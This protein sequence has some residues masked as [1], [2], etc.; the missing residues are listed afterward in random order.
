MAQHWKEPCLSLSLT[1]SLSTPKTPLCDYYLD[2]HMDPAT[3]RV[4]SFPPGRGDKETEQRKR[5]PVHG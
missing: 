3:K 4:L 2:A 1:L 5:T